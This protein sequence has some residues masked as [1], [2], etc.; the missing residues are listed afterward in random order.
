MWKHV[1]V[2]Q[3]SGTATVKAGIHRLGRAPAR[4]LRFDELAKNA[5]G[6]VASPRKEETGLPAPV[7]FVAAAMSFQPAGGE[8]IA[9]DPI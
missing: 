6:E 2:L 7:L 9:P 5:L 3:I 4:D 1:K 8:A